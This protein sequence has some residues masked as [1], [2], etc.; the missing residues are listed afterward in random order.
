MTYPGPIY[1]KKKSKVPYLIG[2]AILLLFLACCGFFA[3]SGEKKEPADLRPT[4]ETTE[5][6]KALNKAANAPVTEKPETPRDGQ[7]EFKVGKVDCSKTRV[8]SKDFGESAQGTFCIFPLEV[9]NIGKD[10][11]DFM[12]FNQKAWAGTSEFAP[13]DE[14]AI[15]APEGED[16]FIL[17]TVN[18]GNV[19]KGKLIFDVPKGTKLT[20]LQLHDSAFS[21]GVR[22]KL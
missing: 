1:P 6:A 15:Y 8:G 18:P 4:V 10:P 12:S 14:A 17:S 2:A 3:L 9:R 7:F 5:S 21:N 16:W 20:H 19:T 22:I 11:Q 13:D